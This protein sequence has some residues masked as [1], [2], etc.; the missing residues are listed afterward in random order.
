MPKYGRGLNREIVAAVNS[1]MIQEPFSI[2]DVRKLI[3]A[4]N[5]K[6]EPRD[7]YNRLCKC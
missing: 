6:P 1:G 3:K 4:K 2:K 5:W 7:L